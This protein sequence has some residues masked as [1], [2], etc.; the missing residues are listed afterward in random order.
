MVK[1]QKSDSHSLPIV[2][3]LGLHSNCIIRLRYIYFKDCACFYSTNYRHISKPTIV[4][5]NTVQVMQA[6]V[7]TTQLRAPMIVMKNTMKAW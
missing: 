2:G 7:R 3:I 1:V 6:K 4:M 5:K